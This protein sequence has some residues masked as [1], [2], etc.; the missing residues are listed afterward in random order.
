MTDERRPDELDEKVE[1]LDVPPEEGEDVKGGASPQLMQYC[2][3]GE[4]IKKVKLD[5]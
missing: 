1:D 2:A 4:H 3:G 5:V